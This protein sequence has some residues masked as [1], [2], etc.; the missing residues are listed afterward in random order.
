MRTKKGSGVR[1]ASASEQLLL[2]GKAEALES[3]RQNDISGLKAIVGE[4]PSI[5][6]RMEWTPAPGFDAEIRASLEKAAPS[7]GSAMRGLSLL[8]LAIRMRRAK[9]VEFLAPLSDASE[10][11]SFGETPLMMAISD[12]DEAA[13]SM[14]KALLPLS[15]AN[16]RS[17]ESEMTALMMAASTGDAKVIK[18]LLPQSDAR[19]ASAHGMTALHFA[20]DGLCWTGECVEILLP[21][22]DLG[23]K[24]QMGLTALALANKSGLE[25]IARA[26]EEF[27]AQEEKKAIGAAIG[28]ANEAA[29]AG[30]VRL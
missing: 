1:P 25:R 30:A 4:M 24:N 9:M 18:L 11:N 19:M 23:A 20:V 12:D 7:Q 29:A 13:Q 22:S 10:A 14:V 2:R 17:V 26:I 6:R 27:M 5:C 21:V 28:A 16:K 8:E 15:D 3:I